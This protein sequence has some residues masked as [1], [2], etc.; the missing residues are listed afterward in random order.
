L[1]A[2]FNWPFALAYVPG[3]HLIVSDVGS[4]LLRDLD[5]KT[6]KVTTLTTTPQIYNLVYREQDDAVYYSE[7]SNGS[8]ERFDLKA[9]AVTTVLFANPNMPQPKALCIDQ[10]H[11]Y[12]A[13][14]ELPNIYELQINDKAAPSTVSTSL[15]LVGTGS[16]VLGMT[17]SDGILYALQR[18]SVPL[19]RITPYYQPVTLG[20]AWDTPVE[21]N[22]QAAPLFYLSESTMQGFAASPTE[23][24]KL[25][26]ASE[27]KTSIISVKDYDFPALWNADQGPDFNYATTKPKNTYRILV[28]GDSRL[29]RAPEVVSKESWTPSYRNSTYPKKLE[30][31]LNTEAALQNVDTHYEVLMWGHVNECAIFFGNYEIP[32][33]VKKYDI[34]KVMVM[35]SMYFTDYFEKIWTAEGIPS[36]DLIDEYRHKPIT[37][38]IPPGAP[39]KFFE[40]CKKSGLDTKTPM[41][42]YRYYLRMENP[43]I[44]ADLKEMMGLPL[45]LLSNKL[46][47]ITLKDGKA[48]QLSIFYIPWDG[49]PGAEENYDLFWKNICQKNKVEYISIGPEFDAL[50]TS[51]YPVNQSDGVL[52]Y[53][54][55]GHQLIAYLLSRYL[56]EQKLIPFESEKPAAPPP[57]DHLKAAAP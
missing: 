27:S 10:N 12:V 7:P 46:S 5:L 26:I 52:H 32:D 16:H 34:D 50:Q 33:L 56:L 19:A 40:D 31:L 54:A 20:T 1:Q 21:N 35:A 45:H 3:D 55:Y 11:I 24:R 22:S 17:Y 39:A 36:H 42:D 44:V 49:L 43:A 47:A 18:G 14:A 53:T 25:Y 15:F 29:L 23:K 4:H 28:V 57:D 37:S 38:R 13:D 9:K 30:L 2:S 51:Y 48:P 8:I 6:N 41:T